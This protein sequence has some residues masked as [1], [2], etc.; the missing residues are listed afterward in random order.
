[1]RTSVA[2]RKMARR[3][4]E[5]E[6]L[7]HPGVLEHEAAEHDDHDRRGGGDDAGGRGESVGDRVHRVAGLVVLLA[8]T[9]Q[10]R[11]TS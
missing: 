6:H 11:N 8:D 4:P 10:S 5:A 3:E 2:S 9:R 1:M 7:D